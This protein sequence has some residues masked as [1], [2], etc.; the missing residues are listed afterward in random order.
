[1]SL[2]SG[3]VGWFRGWSAVMSATDFQMTQQKSIYIYRE[4]YKDIDTDINIVERDRERTQLWKNVNCRILGESL[5]VLLFYQP[6]LYFKFF[7]MKSWEEKKAQKQTKEIW[8]I[9]A[10]KIITIFPEKKNKNQKTRHCSQT[11]TSSMLDC[12]SISYSTGVYYRSVQGLEL[13]STVKG[14]W[15]CTPSGS[16]PWAAND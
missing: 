6:C 16:C 3:D 14:K 1:M 9:I 12:L 4:S 10:V 2:S 8:W 13:L 7:K 15:K 5:M 11:E